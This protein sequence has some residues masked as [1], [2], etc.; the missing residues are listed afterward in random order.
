MEVSS[1]N[2]LNSDIEEKALNSLL[3]VFGSMF[4]LQEIASAYCNAGRNVD[5]A[6]EF[7]FDQQ[8]SVS[9]STTQPPNGEARCKESSESINI[10]ISEPLYEANGKFRA[11]KTKG[12]TVSAGTI[13]S[14]IGKDYAEVVQPAN[15]SCVA[16]KPLKLDLEFPMSEIWGEEAKP[17]PPKDDLLPKDM[18]DFLFK[19]LGEGFR[20]ERGVIREVLES[21]GYDMKKSM[22]KLLDRSEE[23][24]DR[25]TESLD[26]SSEKLTEHPNSKG[27]DSQR[28][29]QQQ[30]SSG[31]SGDND[32]N[33]SGTKLP[34]QS[35]E[36]NELQ[37]EVLAALFYAPEK[38]EELPKRTQKAVA[39]RRSRAFGTVVSEPPSDF[40]PEP[41]ANVFPWQEDSTIVVADEDEDDGYQALRK[42]VMENRGMRKEYYKAAVAAFASGDRVLADQLMEEGHRYHEKA[43]QADDESNQKIVE[44]KNAE[45]ESNM[46]LDLHDFEAKEA[47]RLLRC[48]LSRISGIS[49][50]KYLKVILETNDADNKK[51]T[52]R[53]QVMKLLDKESIEWNEEGG[54]PGTILIRIDIIDPKRLSFAKK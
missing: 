34:R 13:S 1:S 37:K 12:R 50:F 45:T 46:L 5:L 40:I 49:S 30:N 38:F 16:T 6:G 21:C 4:T 28:N 43:R 10:N 48:H 24:S 20:M 14:V 3:D 36:R 41:K 29:L 17:N 25:R 54:N 27:L 51:G 39:V 15:G 18:E 52:R 8:A 19:L 42:A 9:T 11:S 47:I 53:R 7:L 26:R 44:T 23:T 31:C 33:K 22:L 35:K 32:A 2:G